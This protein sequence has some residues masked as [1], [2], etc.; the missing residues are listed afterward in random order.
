METYPTIGLDFLNAPNH[1]FV[2]QVSSARIHFVYSPV[3]WMKKLACA[4]P[5]ANHHSVK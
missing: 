1:D 2:S 5:L 4:P 3:R